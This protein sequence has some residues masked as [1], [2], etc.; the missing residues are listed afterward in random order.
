MLEILKSIDSMLSCL[1]AVLPRSE[2]SISGCSF[3]AEASF[4]NRSTTSSCSSERCWSPHISTGASPG[5]PRCNQ[6]RNAICRATAILKALS[7]GS[8]DVTRFWKQWKN[9]KGIGQQQAVGLGFVGPGLLIM[10]QR[11]EEKTPP[12]LKIRRQHDLQRLWIRR[13]DALAP[14]TLRPTTSSSCPS[15][16]G[17]LSK[18]K[19]SAKCCS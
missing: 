19:L 6:L 8:S 15:A 17:R 11:K 10:H 4:P 13:V 3:H 14:G 2:A 18:P 1:A 5:L 16:K 12:D 7:L 9:G